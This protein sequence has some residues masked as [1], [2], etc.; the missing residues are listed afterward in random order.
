MDSYQPFELPGL[1]CVGP[2]QP[3]T[4]VHKVCVVDGPFVIFPDGHELVHSV[5]ANLVHHELRATQVLLH[6]HAIVD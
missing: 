1:R 2:P 5:L 4:E 6:K 3:H